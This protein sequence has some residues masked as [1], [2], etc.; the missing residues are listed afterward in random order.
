MPFSNLPI[1]F[2]FFLFK[3]ELVSGSIASASVKTLHSV[4]S[5]NYV[6]NSQRKNDFCDLG[7]TVHTLC[8]FWTCF[9]KV[10]ENNVNYQV[11]VFSLITSAYHITSDGSRLDE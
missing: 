9:C 10:D 2:S 8:T 5:I 6:N 11:Y 4:Y 1:N 7:N 3:S